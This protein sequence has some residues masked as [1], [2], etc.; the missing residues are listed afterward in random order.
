MNLDRKT[1][2]FLK[3]L[4][5]MTDL[6]DL[7]VCKRSK[8]AAIVYPGDF[9]RI[10]SIGYNGPPSGLNHDHCTGQEG[11]CGCVHAEANAIIK[12]NDAVKNA[13]MLCTMSPCYHCAGLIINSRSIGAVAYV[14]EYRDTTGLLLLKEAGIIHAR[15]SE[16]CQAR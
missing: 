5:F 9:T 13:T 14:S 10:L 4:K 15:V 6:E 8:C 12:L 2:K 16:R 1:N 7:S 3:F 11:L